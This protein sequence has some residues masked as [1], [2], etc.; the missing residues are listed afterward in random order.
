MMTALRLLLL[1]I[2][3]AIASCTSTH[4]GNW[5]PYT[6]N[7]KNFSPAFEGVTGA[8]WIRE[9]NYPIIADEAP[10]RATIDPLPKD[11]GAVAGICYLQTTGGKIADHNTFTPYP[12]E[13][14][15]F[16]SSVDGVSVARTDKNGYFLEYLLIGDY[17]VF[18][19]GVKSEF[20]I[21]RGETTFIP[22]RGGK[23]M[24]D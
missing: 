7:G 19:R 9:G 2:L 12:D 6:F 5:Q 20:R 22:I 8:V 24:A 21:R 13:R 17:E 11:T 4:S 1:M 10:D 23:R 16:K 14:I 3:P 15:T 18:C